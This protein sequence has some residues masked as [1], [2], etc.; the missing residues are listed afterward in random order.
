MPLNRCRVTST[1]GIVANAKVELRG[2]GDEW[3]DISRAVRGV[4]VELV[5]GTA[6]IARIDTIMV[7]ATV[8]AARLTYSTLDAFAATLRAHGWSAAPPDAEEEL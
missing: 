1:E 4:A 6:S 8:E 2:S 5:Y 3:V 7:D